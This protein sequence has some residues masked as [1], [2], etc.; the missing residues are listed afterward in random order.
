M[1]CKSF[2]QLPL[3]FVIINWFIGVVI[4]NNIFLVQNLDGIDMYF[5]IHHVF[6]SV[7]YALPESLI[8]LFVVSL[9]LCH[10]QVTQ[11]T[12]KNI[13]YLF[14][15]SLTINVLIYLCYIFIFADIWNYFHQ[16]LHFD[17]QLTRIL[18]KCLLI[19]FVSYYAIINL[20]YMFDQDLNTSLISDDNSNKIH[21]ILF[22]TL[23]LF[24][25]LF[26]LTIILLVRYDHYVSF[27]IF[28]IVIFII[29]SF[30]IRNCFKA[31][32]DVIQTASIVKSS[33]ISFILSFI[34]N[35]IFFVIMVIIMI[36]VAFSHDQY[37]RFI[38]TTIVLLG[39]ILQ[40]MLNCL[41]FRVFTKRYFGRV[42]NE[43]SLSS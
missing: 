10:C 18:V 32:F 15:V 24:F 9:A 19:S 37:E 31:K 34:M 43:I 5:I 12:L 13:I 6:K 7:F 36:T 3:F 16:Y 41:I 33:L 26:C 17:E 30:T 14:I 28:L 38:L 40:I 29:I 20:K 2:F 25:Y 11:L 21:F 8:A 4:S 35:Y 27:T 22:V 23:S 42:I 1:N 39:F